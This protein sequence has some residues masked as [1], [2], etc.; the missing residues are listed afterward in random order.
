MEISPQ[1]WLKSRVDIIKEGGDS[2]TNLNQT[3]AVVLVYKPDA[4]Q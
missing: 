2:Y 4:F 1:I 3:K